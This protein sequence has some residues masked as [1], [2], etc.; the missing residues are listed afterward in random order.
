MCSRAVSGAQRRAR[1]PESN[2]ARSALTE[3]LRA[4]GAVPL[5]GA[6][7]GARGLLGCFF[8]FEG[9]GAGGGECMALDSSTAPRARTRPAPLSERVISTQAG[10]SAPLRRRARAGAGTREGKGGCTHP[11]RLAGARDRSGL[12]GAESERHCVWCSGLCVEE[13]RG[14]LTF[15]C[16]EVWR[17]G[18]AL[19]SHF[20]SFACWGDFISRWP[21]KPERRGGGERGLSAALFPPRSLSIATPRRRRALKG[22]V[23]GRTRASACVQGRLWQP[24]KWGAMVGAIQAAARRAAAAALLL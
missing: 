7:D 20:F 17:A 23:S 1:P 21:R 10:A 5:D 8:C 3:E 2:D 15:E 13:K 14:V 9:R 16:G 18:A 12:A 22:F 6:R 19:S 11:G 24:N 4:V